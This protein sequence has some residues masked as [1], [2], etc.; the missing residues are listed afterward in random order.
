MVTAYEYDAYGNITAETD[1]EYAPENP[2]RFSTKFHDDDTGWVYYGYR[3]YGPKWGRWGS[4]DPIGE[5]GEL[6]VYSFD[7]CDPV[8]QIDPL[9]EL[10]GMLVPSF[11]GSA[12]CKYREFRPL[13]FAGF[14]LA[15]HG[16]R[17]V[18][19]ARF[20]DPMTCCRC[21]LSDE[22]FLRLDSATQ[23]ACCSCRIQRRR[24]N[25]PSPWWPLGIVGST[26]GAH[27]SMVIKCSDGRRW[28]LDHAPIKGGPA[29]APHVNFVPHF[30][31]T[32]WE[33]DTFV[34]SEWCVACE[35]AERV[36][37]A[38]KRL[39]GCTYGWYRDCYWFIRQLQE[40]LEQAVPSN[41]CP[42]IP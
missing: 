11:G 35:T 30:R 15:G 13:A 33:G 3:Y 28:T 1:G 10:A 16:Q 9:G 40:E 5:K 22:P 41:G 21:S 32:G 2:F 18:F 25:S 37:A 39:D 12:C 19:C 38:A 26:Y 4:R 6:G 7:R 29:S 42:E 24:L 27:E 17:T 8:A 34:V 14:A 31:Q 20:S 36:V 23:G